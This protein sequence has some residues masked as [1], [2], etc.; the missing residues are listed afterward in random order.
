[1]ASEPYIVLSLIT[2]PEEFEQGVSRIHDL[3]KSQ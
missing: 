3:V 2:A 1:M